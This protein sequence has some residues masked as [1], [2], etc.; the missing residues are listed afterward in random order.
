MTQSQQSIP[1]SSC[2][3]LWFS[4]W[5]FAHASIRTTAGTSVAS[6]NAISHFPKNLSFLFL[7]LVYRYILLY[8]TSVSLWLPPTHTSKTASV[9]CIPMNPSLLGC[10]GG[11]VA[12][13]C[14]PI[15]C[16]CVYS[17]VSATTCGLTICF[18]SL[19]QR[20]LLIKRLKC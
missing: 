9:S 13:F 4:F 6:S 19:F 11:F 1:S 14:P 12:F 7:V 2:E 16:L 20:M 8:F 10:C 5:S 15:L 3:P 17:R 18:A